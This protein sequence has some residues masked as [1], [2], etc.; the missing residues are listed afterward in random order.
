MLNEMENIIV[1]T[2][3]Q[4]MKFKK[5]NKII[6]KL[7]NNHTKTNI[8]IFADKFIK[9]KL[10]NLKKIPIVSEEGFD[11]KIERPEEYFIID[12]I[13]GTLS[14]INNFKTWV[15]QIAYIK[16][17]EVLFAVIYEPESDNLYSASKEKGVFFN[18]KTYKKKIFQN[19]Q[20]IFIDNTPKPNL[21][22]KNIMRHYPKSKY[23]ESGSLSLKI[24]KIIIGSANVFIKDV[25]VRDWDIAPPLLLANLT[26]IDIFDLS[27][28]SYRL[29][30]GFEKKGLIVCNQELTKNLL[31]KIKN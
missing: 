28:N 8:D 9:S 15:T 5:N 4:I 16:K 27:F 14:L 3:L 26:G 6:K 11:N 1:E 22:N 10:N 23:I 13:D 29:S 31:N 19:S 25:N 17:G 2:G 24:C 12:P 7:I 18:K 21:L 30:G 20:I